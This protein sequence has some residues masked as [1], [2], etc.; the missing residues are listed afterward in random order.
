M[1]LPTLH[2]KV[3]TGVCVSRLIWTPLKLVPPRTNFSAIIG[4]PPEKYVPRG[5]HVLE[6]YDMTT[7]H[8][9]ERKVRLWRNTTI[10]VTGIDIVHS[11]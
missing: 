1:I 8:V 7:V 10:D 6:L 4:P 9:A 2:K 3:I 11:C 5:L